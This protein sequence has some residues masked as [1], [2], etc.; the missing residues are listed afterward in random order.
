MPVKQGKMRELYCKKQSPDAVNLGSYSY[1]VFA[2]HLEE[3]RCNSLEICKTL[4]MTSISLKF[5][6]LK[7]SAVVNSEELE[8]LADDSSISPIPFA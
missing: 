1:G 5:S 6:S 4:S 3:L 2:Q 7:V 8:F